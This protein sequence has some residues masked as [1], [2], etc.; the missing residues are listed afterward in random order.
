M[1]P[2]DK[3]ESLNTQRILQNRKKPG[4]RSTLCS[5]QVV[6]QRTSGKT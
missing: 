4:K 3:T 6:L 5:D 2:K 1:I